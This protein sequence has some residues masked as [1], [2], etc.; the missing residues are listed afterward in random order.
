M[1]K[2]AVILP[3]TFAVHPT[4][5]ARAIRH[6]YK[7]E[8]LHPIMVP[9]AGSQVRIGL[10]GELMEVINEQPVA[11]YSKQQMNALQKAAL[12]LL[13]KQNAKN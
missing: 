6:M 9:R 12:N 5:M 10:R 11:P 1:S 8:A 13:E 2:Q 3:N 4:V 7:G